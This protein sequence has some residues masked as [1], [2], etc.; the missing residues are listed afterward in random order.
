MSITDFRL[1]SHVQQIVGNKGTKQYTKP[2]RNPSR[3][4]S[5]AVILL[6]SVEYTM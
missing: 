2:A 3:K 5:L 1:L 4:M 6:H